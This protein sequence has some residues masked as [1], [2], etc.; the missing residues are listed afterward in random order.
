MRRSLPYLFMVVMAG[1]IV[2][3][4]FGQ[5]KPL[6]AKIDSI[7]PSTPSVVSDMAGLLH[8]PFNVLS[9]LQQIRDSAHLNLVVVTLP[10]LNFP[11]SVTFS[12]ED[13]AREIGR[14]WLVA[15]HNDT[16]AAQ[17]RNT[18]GVIVLVKDSHMCRVEVATG[19][20]GYLTDGNAAQLCR[21]A[22]DNFRAGQFDAGVL[23]IANGFA[24]RHTASLASNQSI[25]ATTI[26]TQPNEHVFWYWF[27]GFVTLLIGLVAVKFI[28]DNRIQEQEELEVQRQRD[29]EYEAL[30][31]KMRQREAEE[32]ADIEIAKTERAKK[33]IARLAALTPEE[34]WTEAVEAKRLLRN[35]KAAEKRR[36]IKNDELKSSSSTIVFPISDSGNSSSTDSGYSGGSSSTDSG[37]SGGGSDSFSGGGGGSSW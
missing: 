14:K 25:A 24:T 23:Q 7:L 29:I 18:G 31:L 33:E 36:Q 34:R 4:V 21:D 37:Y 11:N 30:V 2:C 5:D 10:T 27:G 8:N 12:I 26:S 1:L 19:S 20:E 6:N 16:V 32:R 35:A 17:S 15:L 28:R 22:R 13:V 3:P 9:Q